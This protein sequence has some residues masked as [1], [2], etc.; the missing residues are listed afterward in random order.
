VTISDE[1]LDRWDARAN[2]DAPCYSFGPDVVA[3]LVAEA[4]RLREEHMNCD[5]QL[6]GAMDAL[7]TA[8]ENPDWIAVSPQVKAKVTAERDALRAENET[9]RGLLR[10]ILPWL[11]PVEELLY[12]GYGPYNVRRSNLGKLYARTH[13]ALADGG[14]SGGKTGGPVIYLITETLDTGPAVTSRLLAYALSLE[15]AQRTVQKLEAASIPGITYTIDE[16]PYVSTLDG[17]AP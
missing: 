15:G 14:S 7:Q 17:V 8:M 5:A 11:G 13:S 10:D 4:R 6:N 1:D 3:A 2:M 9:L 16:V 12:E